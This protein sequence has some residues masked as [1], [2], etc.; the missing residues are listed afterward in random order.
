[1][2]L[3][4]AR[5]RMEYLFEN[6][7]EALHTDEYAIAKPFF[8]NFNI[9]ETILYSILENKSAGVIFTDNKINPSFVLVCSPSTVSIPNAYAYLS[10][11]LNESSLIRVASYLKT[12]PKISLVVP[13]DWKFRFFF[14]KL[15]FNSIERMQ[16]RRPF[17]F[18]NLDNWKQS[19][20]N[21]YTISKIDKK[22]FSQCNWH[23]F[24]LSCYG[25]EDHFFASGMG[26]CLLDQEKIISESYGLIANGKAEIGVITDKNY[27]S[28]NLGTI[29]SAIVLDYCY[30][31]N[32][33]P[34][35]NCDIS[36]SASMAIAKKL[37]FEEDCKYCFL[38]WT[39]L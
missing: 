28:Q 21:Q 20:P 2:Q 34:Y 26:F 19:L 22:N 18:F 32:I 1:M 12:L 5:E 11:E 23:S 38:K 14:E 3:V 25:D 9:Y 6:G 24:I 13:F 7:L 29:I 35:W 37:G 4:Q 15:G 36:N 17:H 27:R 10:G 39:S 16:L 33:E 30:K 31:Y 8:E